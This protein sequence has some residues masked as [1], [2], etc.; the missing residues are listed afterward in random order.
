MSTRTERLRQLLAEPG[1]IVLPGCH[2]VISA[3][4]MERA[5]FPLAFMSGLAVSAARLAAP[6]TGL[7]SFGEMLDQGRDICAA[8]S[9][10]VIGDG[11]TGYGNALNVKRTVLDEAESDGGMGARAARAIRLLMLTGCRRNEILTLRWEHVDLEAGELRLPDTKTGARMVP[12][13]PT[14]ARVLARAPRIP[15]NPWVFPGAKAGA[16]LSEL[17]YWW[18]ELRARAGLPN[19]RLHDLSHSFAS[20]A[21]A[22]G[23]SLSI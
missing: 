21:L 6:D 2:D 13:S 14:A 16:H 20:R 23:Q 7:I 8:V 12:V 19:L 11:D 17:A 3:R 18:N 5:G 1:L 22:L 10:P 15:G 9:I 4:I